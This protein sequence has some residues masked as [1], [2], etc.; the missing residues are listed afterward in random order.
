MIK[1]PICTVVI[2]QYFRKIQI[3]LEDVIY[4]YG[5]CREKKN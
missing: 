3:N 1:V 5:Q 2:I 4:V